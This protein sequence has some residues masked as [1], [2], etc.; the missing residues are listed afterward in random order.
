MN[1]ILCVRALVERKEI[2]EEILKA[3]VD[4]RVCKLGEVAAMTVLTEE[5]PEPHFE[6]CFSAYIPQDDLNVTKELLA[7]YNIS[8][9]VVANVSQLFPK[10]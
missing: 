4:M 2:A 6:W 10:E 5:R 9:V 1:N 8:S 3:L 7:D